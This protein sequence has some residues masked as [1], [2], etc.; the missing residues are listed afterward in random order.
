[1][2]LFTPHTGVTPMQ[3]RAKIASKMGNRWI[4]IVQ[5][6]RWKSM[7]RVPTRGRSNDDSASVLPAVARASRP[8]TQA[9]ANTPASRR[10][11]RRQSTLLPV[12]EVTTPVL[13]PALLVRL[14]AERL[15]LAV[16][17]GLD[18]ISSNAALYQSVTDGIRTAIAQGQIVFRRSPF[19]AV[20][21]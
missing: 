18:V 10:D 21:L 19:V 6:L 14:G 8:R 2:S 12:D 7:N 11:N 1:M 9:Q 20:T 3:S 5:Y 16:A 13:L 4:F 15:F 17:D